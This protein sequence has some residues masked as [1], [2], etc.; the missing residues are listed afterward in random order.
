MQI[1]LVAHV[2]EVRNQA[3]NCT[4]TLDDGGGRFEARHWGESSGEDDENSIKY[5]S[6]LPAFH[7]QSHWYRE[8]TYIRVMG[9]LKSFGGK[10]YINAT[11]VRPCQDPH[12]PYF[13]KLDTMTVSLIMQRGPVSRYAS[14][15]A[16]TFMDVPPLAWP[17]K[18]RSSCGQRTI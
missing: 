2:V 14:G 9:G 8:N 4:Y 17:A 15:L 10:T 3:T 5:V 6:H 11:H 12:E 7:Q 1:T 18:R 13:H 16:S